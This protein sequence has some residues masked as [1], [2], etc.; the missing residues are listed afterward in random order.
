MV[1]NRVNPAAYSV[2]NS[3]HSGGGALSSILIY[4][5]F[6]SFRGDGWLPGLITKSELHVAQKVI[7]GALNGCG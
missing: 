4:G 7:S 1:Q 5:A 2:A 3:T 6:L